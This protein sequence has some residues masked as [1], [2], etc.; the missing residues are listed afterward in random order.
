MAP[1]SITPLKERPSIN[2]TLESP[3]FI[4]TEMDRPVTCPELKTL[5]E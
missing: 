4:K 1:F 5:F 2:A 3:S